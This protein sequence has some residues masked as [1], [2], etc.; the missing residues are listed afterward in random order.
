MMIEL[1]RMAMGIKAKTKNNCSANLFIK[2]RG[3]YLS[4]ICQTCLSAL[5]PNRRGPRSFLNKLWRRVLVFFLAIFWIFEAKFL[6]P[7]T[8]FI[9]YDSN[10]IVR[11]LS[12]IKIW[13]LPHTAHRFFANSSNLAV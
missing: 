3:T 6:G 4:Q 7:A 1:I 12:T 11:I 2:Y 8:R 13:I 10:I 9:G 5:Q